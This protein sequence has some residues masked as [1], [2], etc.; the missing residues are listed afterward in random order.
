MKCSPIFEENPGKKEKGYGMFL[1]LKLVSGF[2]IYQSAARLCRNSAYRRRFWQE[3]T[4]CWSRR[5]PE[6]GWRSWCRGCRSES[7]RNPSSSAN[8]SARSWRCILLQRTNEKPLIPHASSDQNNTLSPPSGDR[9]NKY[10][11]LIKMIFNTQ[12]FI[13]ECE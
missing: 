3:R 12:K 8:G 5:K 13:N 2:I 6:R 7:G 4:P 11:N 10:M 9:K 1:L